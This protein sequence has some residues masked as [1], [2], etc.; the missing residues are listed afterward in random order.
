[1]RNTLAKLVWR[2]SCALPLSDR[3]CWKGNWEACFWNPKTGRGMQKLRCWSL[4][5]WRS[6]FCLMY[7]SISSWNC[8]PFTTDR[9]RIERETEKRGKQGAEETYVLGNRSPTMTRSLTN[10]APRIL[11]PNTLSCQSF[12]TPNCLLI[13]WLGDT[14]AHRKCE[15]GT[16]NKFLPFST[17]KLPPLESQEDFKRSTWRHIHKQY[18]RWKNRDANCKNNY[19][20]AICICMCDQYFNSYSYC[21]NGI[22]NKNPGA[23]NLLSIDYLDIHT[24]MRMKYV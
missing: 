19:T 24:W 6:S 1:M 18:D 4:H 12:S 3:Q 9:E 8:T 16:T 7:D 11:W 15:Y 20:F 17:L 21:I 22:F 13:H 2:E 14:P 23:L 5:I 10:D